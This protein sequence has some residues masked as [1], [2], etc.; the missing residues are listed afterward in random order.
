[1]PGSAE[2]GDPLPWNRVV[3][4]DEDAHPDWFMPVELPG[5]RNC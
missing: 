4:Q 3:A 5:P 2:T 1:M